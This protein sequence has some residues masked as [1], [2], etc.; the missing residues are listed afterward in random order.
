MAVSA[1]TTTDKQMDGLP[2]AQVSPARK[3]LSDGFGFWLLLLPALIFF[4]A[5]F[6]VPT[7]SLF[8]L[9]FN[10]SAAGVITLSSAITFDNFVRIFTR[11]IYYEAILRSVGIAAMVAL[12]CLVLGYPLAYV[13]A[14]T[15]NPGRNTIAQ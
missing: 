8:A 5:F 14:K 3:R 4:I 7:A 15:V 12:V 6:V 9:A 1:M 2:L 11:A 13:I 10:K